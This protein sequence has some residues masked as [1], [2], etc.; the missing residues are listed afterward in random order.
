MPRE[1]H[2]Q[3]P[4]K[5]RHAGSIMLENTMGDDPCTGIFF[6][7]LRLAPAP[8]CQRQHPPTGTPRGTRMWCPRS[9]SASSCTMARSLWIIGI[10]RA[11]TFAPSRGRTGSSTMRAGHSGISRHVITRGISGS[12]TMVTA[13]I[14]SGPATMI[15]TASTTATAKAGPTHRPATIVVTTAPGTGTIAADGNCFSRRGRTACRPASF[16]LLGV[17]TGKLSGQERLVY[18]GRWCF[19]EPAALCTV[20]DPCCVKRGRE[21]PRAQRF[22][23]SCRLSVGRA[24]RSTRRR[25][26]GISCSRRSSPSSRSASSSSASRFLGVGQ[27]MGSGLLSWDKERSRLT[28]KLDGSCRHPFT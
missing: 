13:T 27:T 1:Y 3:A 15:A 5:W 7:L 28:A 26:S 23:G 19:L 14:S 21:V 24:E 12:A 17:S 16:G 8:S 6:S 25:R 9:I 18:S 22:F 10:R 2:A 4:F 20:A 11:A